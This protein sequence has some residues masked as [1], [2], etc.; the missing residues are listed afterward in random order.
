M[1]ALVT[2]LAKRT[3]HALLS[4][5]AFPAV[6]HVSTLSYNNF[7]K[8]VLDDKEL[9]VI[10]STLSYETFLTIKMVQREIV[11]NSHTFSNQIPFILVMF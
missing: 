7:R 4:T 2:Q 11:I 8:K 3:H 9:I 1:C 10:L 5:V 6:P